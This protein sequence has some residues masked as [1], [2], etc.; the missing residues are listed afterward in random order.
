[1]ERKYETLS[2]Y[3]LGNLKDFDFEKILELI[4]A[5]K[6]GKTLKYEDCTK[7]YVNSLFTPLL[8]FSIQ[9]LNENE[10]KE[11]II[12]KSTIENIDVLYLALNKNIFDLFFQ[13]KKGNIFYNEEEN[14]KELMLE[15][16]VLLGEKI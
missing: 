6:E 2:D 16:I 8:S 5:I 7:S 13:R 1:M 14:E 10:E 9:Y 3:Q 15:N 12:G 11:C 4:E